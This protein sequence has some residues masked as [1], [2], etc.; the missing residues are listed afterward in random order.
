MTNE[1][2]ISID[3]HHG[4]AMMIQYTS[5]DDA[6]AQIKQR[7]IDHENSDPGESVYSF[8]VIM[9]YSYSAPKIEPC[10]PHS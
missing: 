7:L 9:P 10:V 3:V 5:I 4:E 6:M 2:Q 8:C 1:Q